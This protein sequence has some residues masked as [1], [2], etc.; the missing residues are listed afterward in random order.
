MCVH[1][2]THSILMEE[3]F[4]APWVAI[5]RAVDQC[6]EVYGF[7]ACSQLL[8]GSSCFHAGRRALP[9]QSSTSTKA[10][11]FTTQFELLYGSEGD[12]LLPTVLTHHQLQTWMN[13]PWTLNAQNVAVVEPLST[14]A[15]S[16]PAVDPYTGVSN[17]LFVASVAA[18]PEEPGGHLSGSTVSDS[19]PMASDR[20]DYD[21]QSSWHIQLRSDWREHAVS[22]DPQ[23]GRILRIKTWFLH[24]QHAPRCSHPRIVTLDR[25]DH[26]WLN[27]IREVWADN[28]REGEALHIEYVRP[29]PSHADDQ[30][31]MPHIILTQGLSPDHYGILLTARFIEE[32]RTQL[33]QEAVTSPTWLCGTRAVDLLRISHLVQGRRW[34][35]R[36]GIMFMAENELEPIANGLSIDID[37]RVPPADTDVV[38]FAA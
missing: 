37:I 21:M 19:T 23:E 28:I 2:W 11:S 33:L 20:A 36:S 26:L 8:E 10:V 3:N 24:H 14:L 22:H 25:M 29:Q 35:A 12:T 30:P 32:H 27:D 1:Q 16:I 31:A 4:T 6:I 9:S 7:D 15:V 18:N 38:S 34:I 13:K 5:E 17:S